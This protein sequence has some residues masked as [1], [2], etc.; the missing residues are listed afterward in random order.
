MLALFVEPEDRVEPDERDSLKG[1]RRPNNELLEMDPR[2][3]FRSLGRSEDG[4]IARPQRL[5]AF[6]I[7]LIIFSKIGNPSRDITRIAGK[8]MALEGMIPGIGQT[9]SSITNSKA[10]SNIAQF[11]L[12]IWSKSSVEVAVY[13]AHV[14]SGSSDHRLN[15]VYY[16]SG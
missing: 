7:S 8:M 16:P 5:A 2:L 3:P 4:Q 6:C 13:L 14:S 1:V 15:L 9:R 11:Y 10:M 12:V